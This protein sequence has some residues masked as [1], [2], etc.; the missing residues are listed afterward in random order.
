MRPHFQQTSP[1]LEKSDGKAQSDKPVTAEPN[2]YRV[3]YSGW[4]LFQAEDTVRQ[5]RAGANS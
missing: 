2:I 1:L 5:N 4:N 3:R